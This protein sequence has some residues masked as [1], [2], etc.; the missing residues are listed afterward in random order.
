MIES[1]LLS[2][3]GS[4]IAGKWTDEYDQGELHVHDPG[5][6][7]E[8]ATLSTVGEK[9]IKAAIDAAAD[10]VAKPPSIERR[11]RWLRDIAD[12]LVKNKDEIGRLI[13]LENGKP[14]KEGIGETE[15][16]AGFFSFAPNTSTCST[17]TPCSRWKKAARGQSTTAPSA[18]SA[19]SRPGTFRSR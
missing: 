16:A 18:W 1:K 12:Q 7:E 11:G 8:L 10:A 15:Y 17:P 13:T 2:N 9:G 14:L 6:G 3:K 19:S 4:Y 5:D